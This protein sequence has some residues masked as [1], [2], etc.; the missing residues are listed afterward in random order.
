MKNLIYILLIAI[1]ALSSCEG[2]TSLKKSL[3]KSV[4]DFKKNKKLE[5]IVYYP[6]EYRAFDN[7]TLLNNGYRIEIKNF[8]NMNRHIVKQEINDVEIINKHY[9]ELNSEI[10]VSFNNTSVFKKIVDSTF[11][12]NI[13][14]VS[15]NI[16]LDGIW[17][18]Q[19][20]SNMEN[21]VV[22][23]IQYSELKS[24]IPKIIKLKIEHDGKYKIVSNT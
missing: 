21:V 10:A 3:T 18:N 17:I 23:D 22:L 13:P 14:D 24:N 9:R 8:T 6:K 15:K 2:R 12:L 19:Y 1:I 11:L 4:N 16:V 20:D 7:D 5:K